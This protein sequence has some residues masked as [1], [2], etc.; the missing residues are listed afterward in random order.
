MSGFDS[1]AWMKDNDPQ[2][3]SRAPAIL[4]TLFYLLAE[5]GFVVDDIIRIDAP[6]S[7]TCMRF[8]PPLLAESVTF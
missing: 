1:C 5:T 7:I 8:L 6:P 2:K 4:F 3:Q